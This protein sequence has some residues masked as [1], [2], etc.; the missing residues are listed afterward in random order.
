MLKSNAIYLET[1]RGGI[2][3]LTL[4][5]KIIICSMI[6]AVVALGGS[7]YSYL[8]SDKAANA[9]SKIE[10][11]YVPAVDIASDMSLNS[12]TAMSNILVAI[13]N[14]TK[15]SSDLVDAN[16]NALRAGISN[17]EK[18]IATGNNHEMLPRVSAMF[19]EYAED[20][21]SYEKYAK[22]SIKVSQELSKLNIKLRSEIEALVR[23][24]ETVFKST[25]ELIKNDENADLAATS[26][27]IDRLDALKTI[28]KDAEVVQDIF[29]EITFTGDI[30]PLN[31]AMDIIE[32]MRTLIS[33][34]YANIQQGRNKQ[35]FQLV[36]D[37]QKHIDSGIVALKDLCEQYNAVI[38]ERRKISAVLED[39]N[40]K[41]LNAAMDS[42]A[43][44]A[45][46][47]KTLLSTGRVIAIILVVITTIVC[48][49][50][51]FVMD[52]TI[53]RPIKRMVILVNDLTTG[54]GDLTKRIN[55]SANDELGD[56]A[57]GF[58]KFIENVQ[59]IIGEVKVSA[60]D[61]ASG[62]NQLAATMEELS[63]NFDSQS[64]QIGDIVMNM[65]NISSLS[66]N[67]ANG[68]GESR[69]VLSEA[70]Q[71]AHNGTDQLNGVKD[72]ILMI[73]RQ[74]DALASTIQRL[75]ESSGQIGE[76]LVVIND[77]A[78]QTNLL[79]LNAAIEAARAGEAGRGFAVVADEVKKLAERTQKATSEIEGIISALQKESES[80]SDEM[81][82]ADEV[83]A[84]G[85]RSIDETIRGFG[86]VV[87][88]VD[89]A[90]KDIEN[91]NG[92][93]NEQNS[94]VQIVSEN[95][96]MIAS[97]IE[98]SNS[99]VG[100]VTST[101]SHLQERAERLKLIVE[102]FKIS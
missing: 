34:T 31:N 66:D 69:N 48:A 2:M 94:A 100:E 92:M 65:N 47:T 26:R 78:D 28:T 87:S 9:A 74:T 22:E 71:L 19:A 76:I 58:N 11:I 97:G 23:A 55:A 64:S 93:V 15:E 77:I 16:F 20:A 96:S 12:L 25:I 46:D 84:E 60:D 99:A 29:Q 3:R 18:H 21:A 8:A 72:R 53:A 17:M 56:L 41:M 68:L 50:V 1:N 13:Q 42:I 80:A 90:N 32:E 5:L 95:T 24:S 7:V 45:N 43:V 38:T 36:I 51:I 98:E 59:E 39:I 44:V 79:S 54:D 49:I 89:S 6:I 61:V 14:G 27:R 85:V 70:A 40:V 75:S 81:K 4:A 52:R 37:A 35:V 91:V 73:N 86:E 30:T 88:G 102:K 62:N 33:R 10:N 67:V 101:V 57:A 83:V 82:K 63:A